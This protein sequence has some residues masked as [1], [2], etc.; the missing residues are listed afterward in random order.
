MYLYAEICLLF[1][2][3]V[4]VFDDDGTIEEEK[5]KTHTRFVLTN[6]C[7]ETFNNMRR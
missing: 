3:N 4:R 6:K 1:M 5:K 2:E 7:I